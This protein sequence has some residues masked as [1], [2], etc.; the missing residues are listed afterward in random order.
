MTYRV[1]R[2]PPSPG[3]FAIR[4][5]HGQMTTYRA[6]QGIRELREIVAR[7]ESDAKAALLRRENPQVGEK[8]LLVPRETVVAVEIKAMAA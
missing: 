8:F 7:N 3:S 2:L 5:P 6:D 4:A 1:F